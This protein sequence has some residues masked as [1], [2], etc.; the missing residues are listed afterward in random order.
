MR[1]DRQAGAENR[2]RRVAARAA[3]AFAVSLAAL[4]LGAGKAAHAVLLV[5]NGTNRSTGLVLLQT[6]DVAQA[7][8]TGGETAGYRLTGLEIELR[9]LIL[10]DAPTVTLHSGSATGKKIADFDFTGTLGVIPDLPKLF[11]FEP[12]SAVTLSAETDYWI[13][14][15]A[16]SGTPVVYLAGTA[17]D[18]NSA[19]GWS[20]AD[21]YQSRA[22]L[23]PGSFRNSSADGAVKFV[24]R[25]TVVPANAAPTASNRDIDLDA[26]TDHVFAEADFG[27]SDTDPGDMLASVKIVSLPAS[28]KGTLSLDGTPI[29][30]ADLPRT[31][32]AAQLAGGELVY[33]PPTGQDGEDFASF[34][35]RVNDGTA[36]SQVYTIT[37]D[38]NPPL[39]APATGTPAISGDPRVGQVL[40]AGPGDIADA[41]GLPSTFAY[42]WIRVDG[43][44]ETDIPN[45]TARSYRLVADDEG[46]QVRVALSFTDNAENREMRTSGVYPPGGTVGPARDTVGP[47]R[48]TVVVVPPAN[49][50]ATGTPAISGDPRV[51]Q[52]LTAGWGD[53]A[54]ADGLPAAIAYRWIRV[55]G[56]DETDIANAT[57]RSYRL[58]AADA[59]K[60]VRVAL[61]FTDN[62]GNR[63][64]LT[65]DAYPPGATVEP[66][67][68]DLPVDPGAWLA[69][70]GRAVGDQAVAAVQARLGAPRTAGVSAR[71]AG[72]A[73]RGPDGAREG[74]RGLET[75]AER[76]RDGAG[77]A[78]LRSRTLSGRKAMAGSSVALAGGS[79]ERGFA[80]FWGHGAVNRF[81]GRDGA[82]AVDGEV[83]SASVGADWTRGRMLAGIMV[84]HARGTGGYRSPSGRGTLGSSLT[85]I[86]P[87]GSYALDQRFSL[88]G[89]AGYGEG[90]LER[91]PDGGALLSPDMSL[92]MA[93]VGLRGVLLGGGDGPTLAAKSDAMAVRSRS[94]AV[95]GLAGS[96]AEATRLRFAF[97][98]SR[99]FRIGAVAVVTPS[100]EA[101]LRHDGGDAATGAGADVGAGLAVSD[102]SR[103]VSAAVRAR[104]DADDVRIYGISGTLAYDPAPD[105]ERG[106]SLDLSQTLGGRAAG[107]ADAP[108]ARGALA[109]QG[110]EAGD[111]AR[112]RRRIEARLGYGFGVWGARWTAVP[113]LRLR[114]SETDT[115]L[116]LGGRLV[117]RPAA[118][119]AF[120]LEVEGGRREYADGGAGPEHELG[121]GLG[122]RL[123][124]GRDPQR[125]FELRIGAARSETADDDRPPEHRVNLT[126]TARW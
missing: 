60:Q 56:M 96:E 62:A 29:A 105:T 118:G 9:I 94:E 123:S 122:W 116:R 98:G 82:L 18:A 21:R 52:V 91:K 46:K 10:A 41:D 84:S 86:F 34:D 7:F 104:A 125:A 74:A 31:V 78:G 1:R 79:A 65:S 112:R 81:D 37:I 66:D 23:W 22:A 16:H 53:I 17:E 6:N 19:S 44:D 124:P 102:P 3:V 43:M 114:F 32:T 77:E 76:L 2:M 95:T 64:T 75:L 5:G 70:F 15:E 14:V 100:L 108:F 92:A 39:N 50:P 33:T 101:G 28:G 103:G 4:A 121:L 61:S 88:W 110:A 87:Y 85:A 69:R 24:L 38:V 42:R 106:L 126:A 111:D 36:D 59:G 30:A 99:P 120:A 97:E 113:G 48:D 58:V 8:R 26:D 35:F 89:M 90:R 54:D 49:S 73:V 72:Q 71:L 68:A 47:T 20:I 11:T 109:G 45:A 93:A 107:A 117:E 63:E 115:E 55:D 13:V 40:T 27:F 12:A 83:A 67:G 57:A 119:L 51:G 80:A 25:G